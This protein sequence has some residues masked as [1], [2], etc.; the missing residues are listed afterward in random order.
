MNTVA[1][2]A[3]V[4]ISPDRVDKRASFHRPLPGSPSNTWLSFFE[5]SIINSPIGY[6][7]DRLEPIPSAI[8]HPR[9]SWKTL[10]PTYSF[11]I[12]PQNKVAEWARG[13]TQFSFVFSATSRS[14]PTD[15]MRSQCSV[16][17]FV[18]PLLEAH[19][20]HQSWLLCWVGCNRSLW[21]LTQV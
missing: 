4:L 15:E 5:Q 20:H 19:S 9:P 7:S 14:F 12:G 8:S 1:Q 10:N 17:D 11:I 13:K 16:D 2:R 6:F 18:I 3:M 21:K